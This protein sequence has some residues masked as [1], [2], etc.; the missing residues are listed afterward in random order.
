ML[1]LLQ[2]YRPAV[3]ELTETVVGVTK[4][5]LDGTDCRALECNVGNMIADAHIYTRANQYHGPHWSDVSVAL[6]QSGGI[7]A[8]VENGNITLYN[9]KSLL[10]FINSLYMLNMTGS[11]LLQA[12][13]HSV[14]QYNGDRGEFLQVSG[15]RVVYN[16]TKPPGSRVE[17]VELRCT[18]CDVPTYSKLEPTKTYGTIVTNFLYEGGDGFQ[19]FK[20]CFRFNRFIFYS[21]FAAFVTLLL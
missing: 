20:V 6:V 19:M 13:E 14:S 15:A 1:K 17:S 5:R 21:S 4:V 12:F 2:K 18:D 7:R 11:G 8:S 9:L 3:Y 16:M 10:P